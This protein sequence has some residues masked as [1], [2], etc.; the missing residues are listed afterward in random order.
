MSKPLKVSYRIDLG[1]GD[2]LEYEGELCLL[3]DAFCPK[4]GGRDM[5]EDQIPNHQFDNQFLHL[6]LKCENAFYIGRVGRV[7]SFVAH[8]PV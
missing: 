4:C 3:P 6:C 7:S 8:G 2:P 5:Y 1:I